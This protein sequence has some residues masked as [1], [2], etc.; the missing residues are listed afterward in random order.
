[1]IIEASCSK[2][3]DALAQS[4]SELYDF[5][6]AI[7]NCPTMDDVFHAV[8][9]NEW[10]HLRLRI[11]KFPKVRQNNWVNV[12]DKPLPALF[13]AEEWNMLK[14]LN[15]ETNR[16]IHQGVAPA[17]LLGKFSIFIPCVVFNQKTID[18]CKKAALELRVVGEKEDLEVKRFVPGS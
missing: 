13:S 4:I 14:E 2:F 1:M 17:I 3:L 16:D 5:N 18:L 7:R 8:E 9:S 15:V 10:I 12:S 6:F 11:P